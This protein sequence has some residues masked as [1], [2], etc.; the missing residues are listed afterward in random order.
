MQSSKAAEKVANRLNAIYRQAQLVICINEVMPFLYRRIPIK[1][2]NIH[3]ELHYLQKLL[4]D[5]TRTID[6]REKKAVSTPTPFKLR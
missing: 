1:F 5:T 6:P 4:K 3:Y 2:Y